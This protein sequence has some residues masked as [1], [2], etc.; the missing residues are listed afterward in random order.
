MKKII[1]MLFVFATQLN[2][3]QTTIKLNDFDELKVFDQL[4]VTLIP[5]NENKIVITGTNQGN[6]ETVNKNGLLKVRISLT[7]ILED[8]KDLKVTLYFKN[9]EIIDANEGSNVSCN[10]VFKQ[11]SMVLSAQEGARI[12]AELDVDKASIKAYSGG[13]ISLMGN[14]VTQKVSINSGGI[15]KA[16]DLVTSQ[17]TINISAGGSA[18]INATTLVDAKVNAGGSISI[19]GKPKQIKQQAL[20]GGTI[21]EK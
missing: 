18:D 13:I 14:A 19:Y 10:T 20:A 15:L 1:L 2:F 4:N 16:K 6:V 7:K 9:I 8:N 21:T 12:E 17:T 5:S 3:G 11:I